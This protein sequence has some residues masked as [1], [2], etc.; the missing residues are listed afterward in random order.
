VQHGLLAGQIIWFYLA[1]LLWPMNLIFF[2]PRWD[3]EPDIWWQWLFPL[4]SL[5]MTLLLW[6]LRKKWRA[7]LAGWLFFVGTL[8][9]VL[10][11]FNIFPFIFSFVADHFQYLASLG[12][13]V[14]L[15]AG[16]VLAVQRLA[17]LPSLAAQRQQV[18]MA[19]N[20]LAVLL[21][22]ALAGLTWKQS[23]MYS[24]AAALYRATIDK[25][26]T[27]WMAY[28][29]LGGVLI[30]S[31]H[32]NEAIEKLQQ[33]V[34]LRPNYADAYNNLGL[35]YVALNKFQDAVGY[36]RQATLIN[37][38]NADYHNNLGIALGRLESTKEASDEFQKALAINPNFA[39][40]RTN[41]GS[42]FVQT[43]QPRE[44][45]EQL[46]RAITLNPDLAL[47]YMNSAIA[48]DQLDRP[49]DALSAAEK[50]LLFARSQG[51]SELTQ[52]IT[53]WLINYRLKK[54]NPQRD[55]SRQNASP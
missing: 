24:D 51:Q 12:I 18:R 20:I 5:A 36:H 32:P 55:P 53:R 41:L 37:P 17:Q 7:P 25:N 44:A 39:N 45:L 2:Y 46:Q 8:F 4:A 31:A 14:P 6:L 38:K 1:K 30:L 40:A 49:D 34:Q 10:G 54:F 50:A 21:L 48:Y 13:I 23:H 11:F 29:N 28:N 52:Q 9:P 16:V 3:P 42:A 47:A 27:C 43:H 35:A 19:G 33:A 15:S 22:T 26:P